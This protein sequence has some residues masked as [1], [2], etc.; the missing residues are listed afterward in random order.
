MYDN[1]VISVIAI[2]ADEPLRFVLIEKAADLKHKDQ[3]NVYESAE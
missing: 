2:I 3:H 1:G